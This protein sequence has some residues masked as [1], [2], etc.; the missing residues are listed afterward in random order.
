MLD[1]TI[2]PAMDF[3]RRRVDRGSRTW[4]VLSNMWAAW[5]ALE[6]VHRRNPLIR[7]KWARR[8]SEFDRSLAELATTTDDFFVVQIGACDGLMAD[9]IHAWI[10]RYNWRGV[11]V[12]PQRAEFERLKATYRD[13]H[14]RLAFENAAIAGV[15]G[16]CTLYRVK[17]GGLAADWER[18]IAT[19]LPGADP[20]RFTAEIVPCM[21]FETL[22]SRHRVSRI[23]LLQIDVEGY[24]FEILKRLDFEK[25]HP[26][27]IRYEHRH[28]RPGDQRACQAYLAQRGY[29]ILEMQ[30]D[31]G[32][33][34][35]ELE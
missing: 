27:M 8:A 19:L 28:L 12:E 4:R 24:D 16:T 22:L 7:R 5:R 33:V 15:D 1:R 23:D 18:G 14:D 35:R 3:V 6:S 29:R 25:V 17:D 34:S 32:A 2:D 21:T 26:A 31:T 13:R 11:L 30:F 20:K 9:P 10:V